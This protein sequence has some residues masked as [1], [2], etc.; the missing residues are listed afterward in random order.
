MSAVEACGHDNVGSLLE[1]ASHADRSGVETDLITLPVP[2][3]DNYQQP[4]V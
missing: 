4:G 1:I 3:I 2:W